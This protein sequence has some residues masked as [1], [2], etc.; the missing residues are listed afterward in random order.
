MSPKLW[1]GSSMRPYPE[2]E[3]PFYKPENFTWARHFEENWAIIKEELAPFIAEKAVVKN[4]NSLLYE[5]F[6]N[7]PKWSKLYLFWG[8]RVSN[9]LQK[10]KVLN[11]LFKEIPG[12]VSITISCLEAGATIP[13]HSGDTNGTMRCHFGIETPEESTDCALKVGGEEQY[14]R[15]GK[16]IMFNDGHKHSSWNKTN[17]RRVVFIFDVIRPEFMNKKN[18]ICVFILTRYAS[19][20]YNHSKIIHNSPAFIKTI[21]FGIVLSAI[22]IGKP[23]YNLFKR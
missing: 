3:P 12:L 14:Y 21:L 11:N 2:D 22:Y 16:W 9:E 19:Y 18:M 8:A 1:F 10:C 13:E 17:Q 23:V 15:N 20:Y 6:S 5:H 4:A 7:D